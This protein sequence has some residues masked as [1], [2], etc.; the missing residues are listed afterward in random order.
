[1]CPIIEGH[2]EGCF[3]KDPCADLIITDF[4]MPERTGIELL[5]IQARRGCKLDV[6]NKA[7][8]SAYI[9]DENKKR[10]ESLGCSFI[11]K[12]FEFSRL[13]EWLDE[14]EQ[15]M[16]LSQPLSSLDALSNS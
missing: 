14:C 8:M 15:R 12:P 13:S 5:E 4:R 16:D 11:Q 10:I 9:D 1:M 2:V 7:I 3:R 6:R